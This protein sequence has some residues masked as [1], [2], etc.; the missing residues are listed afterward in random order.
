MERS[1]RNQN[2]PRPARISCT[3]LYSRS[4]GIVSSHAFVL[5]TLGDAIVGCGIREPR[6][7][8]G[9]GCIRGSPAQFEATFLL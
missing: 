1:I 9:Q 3:R 8:V 2:G 4:L 5:T 6:E 7:P